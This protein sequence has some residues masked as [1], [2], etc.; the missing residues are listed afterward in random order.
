MRI[1][2]ICT[3]TGALDAAV[4]AVLPGSRTVW[5][6]EFA[7]GPARILAHR[8]PG[9]PNHRD[10]TQVNWSQVEPVDIV[11]AGFPCQDVSQ[12]GARAGLKHGTRTGIFHSVMVAVEALSPRLVFLENVLGLLTAD[13]DEWPDHVTALWEVAQ[14]WG[15]V[16]SLID[17]KIRKARRK[18]VCRGEWEHRKRYERVRAVRSRKRAVAEFDRERLRSVPRAIATVLG[19][20]AA[21]GYDTQWCCLRASDVG[22][23]HRRE[24][25]FLVARPVA[26]TADVG[27]E[28][29]GRPRGG[30]PRPADSSGVAADADVA[31]SQGAQSA[32]RR[33]LPDGRVATDAA[34]DGRD[35]G[36]TESAGIVGGPD[37]A[38]GGTSATPDAGGDGCEGCAECDGG[39]GAGVAAPFGVDVDGRD[40][41]A[42]DTEGCCGA[43]GCVCGD[44][45]GQQ[46]GAEPRASVG[47][48]AGRT[49]PRV[50]G[51]DGPADVVA[52][53]GAAADAD[54]GVVWE[55][56]V[57]F[58][59]CGGAGFAEQHDAEART[60]WGAYRAAIERWEHALGRPAPAPT[61]PGQ[62]GGQ[63]LSAVFVEFLMGLPAGWVTDVPDLSRNEQ[64]KAL[65][66]GVVVQQAAAAY[67]MLL[68]DMRT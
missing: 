25:V 18:G 42:P 63:R 3:G 56:S 11:T 19:A 24:R 59:G 61:E 47:D 46:V 28:R 21:A 7:D 55:Q 26:D 36:R 27:Y 62:R 64:L 4:E 1:G 68:E 32:G 35:E 5:H 66:N 58:A 39:P 30:W 17:H 15:R 2:S 43:D 54:C 48:S 20:L 60:E 22:A 13:G 12:A 50:R 34:G 41:A 23:P 53:G 33:D 67:A 57:G 16:V 31:G 14:K 6:C 51:G 10:I 9:V 37:A 52:G 40:H 65:G 49:A 44:E 8:F 29:R 45:A 38:V